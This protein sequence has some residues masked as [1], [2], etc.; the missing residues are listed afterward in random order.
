MVPD[1]QLCTGNRIPLRSSNDHLL[2]ELCG[3]E[4][5]CFQLFYRIH[6]SAQC[7][8]RG[9]D[10]RHLGYYWAKTG[11]CSGWLLLSGGN[12]DS[13]S[14]GKAASL[15]AA[16]LCFSIGGTLASGNLDA[17]AF[18][19]FSKSGEHERYIK[20]ASHM[21]TV[22]LLS[23]ALCAIAGGYLASI[24]I[25]LPLLV[26]AMLFSAGLVIAMILLPGDQQ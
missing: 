18:E 20:T 25:V 4:L 13:Y 15:I 11:L 5:L 10:R 6:L 22:A 26:D 12:A 16:A 14:L 19:K 7:N 21:N 24:N 17:I 3:S 1:D 9:T 23:G 8:S 2:F